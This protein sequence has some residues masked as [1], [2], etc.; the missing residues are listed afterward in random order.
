[1][2]LPIRFSRVLAVASAAAVVT[3]FAPLA[4]AD[5]G[6]STRSTPSAAKARV[7]QVS[8][9]IFGSGDTVDV[10]LGVP[11]VEPIDNLESILANSGFPVNVSTSLP[12]D[13]K[14]YKAIW[15]LDTAALTG[16]EQSAL[17][18]F[19]DSGHSLYL[20]GE[21][22]ACCSPADSTD[23]NIIDDLVS[24]G[25]IQVGGFGAADNPDAPEDV[26]SG[27]VDGV[28]VNPNVLTTWYPSGPG[29]M[30]GVAAS[31][32]MT[33]TNFDLQPVAT[34]AVW[35]ATS[36]TNGV[37]RLAILMD[38]N[39]LEQQFWDES[40][41]TAMVVNLERFLMSAFPTPQTPNSQWAGY[42]AK[43]TGVMDV[44]GQ[45]TVP[46]VSCS[47]S[48]KPS[49]M[50]VWVGIDGFGNKELLKA[51]LGVTCSEP[52][53]SPCY[54][55]YTQVAPGGQVP[56]VPGDCTEVAPGDEV[57]VDLSNSPFGTSSFVAT[58]SDNGSTVGQ[59]VMLMNSDRLD[60]SAEC[61][62]QMPQRTDHPLPTTTRYDQL[63]DFGSVTFSQCQATATQVA[64]SSPDVDQL[65]SGSDGA[66]AVSTLH[67]GSGSK[68]R[69]ATTEPTF[70][71]TSWTVSWMSGGTKH[72][73]NGSS[74]RR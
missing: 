14:R 58:I 62:V 16:A 61:V 21:N 53:G 65:A 66:F 5:A 4:G 73:S 9:L 3:L 41:T 33:E 72:G 2:Q 55:L 64:G 23:Q 69:A 26:Q 25:G 59:P 28:A 7:G 45:W 52:T 10:G 67:M 70:P 46:T 74:R 22:D 12:T 48:S 42:A 39:W 71:D 31:N 15:V 44:T 54:Y 35:D 40:T 51:G 68:V 36:L 19:V 11:S 30:G 17:E 20:T 8:T 18:S 34:G 47:Q 38:I 49:A 63:S 1:M 6:A 24:G 50:G 43:A 27:A 57:S 32:V 60:R 13:L 56:L 29:G 37:G